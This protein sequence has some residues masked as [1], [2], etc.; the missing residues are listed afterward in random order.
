VGSIPALRCRPW[1]LLPHGKR[2]SITTAIN[3]D[4]T[5]DVEAPLNGTLLTLNKIRSG[6]LGPRG[7]RPQA[8]P[9]AALSAAAHLN[10]HS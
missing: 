10:D 7:A 8:W 3:L 2:H 1:A 5:R 9:A 4:Y 6:W